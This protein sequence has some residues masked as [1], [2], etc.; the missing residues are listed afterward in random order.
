MSKRDQAE[1]LEPE[2]AREAAVL[3]ARAARLTRLFRW[4]FWTAMAGLVPTV[5]AVVGGN[6][7][8]HPGWCLGVAGAGQAWLLGVALWAFRVYERIE[9]LE[10]AA[11]V[12]INRHG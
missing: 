3:L 6:W 8:A 1:G 12:A 5:A 10:E 9:T 11:K 7:D 2:A 4:L